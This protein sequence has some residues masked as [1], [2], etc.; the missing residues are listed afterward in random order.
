M[1]LQNL[2]EEYDNLDKR[3]NISKIY[4]AASKLA[5][6]ISQLTH[7]IKNGDT[8]MTGEE[9]DALN[10]PFSQGMLPS[11]NIKPSDIYMALDKELDVGLTTYGYEGEDISFLFD[12][13][14]EHQRMPFLYSDKKGATQKD[15]SMGRIQDLQDIVSSKTGVIST[16]LNDAELAFEE[17]NQ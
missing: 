10:L 6:I 16:E 1:E 2:Y 7:R 13:Y 9:I 3:E 12:F 5:P 14:D 15:H 8:V 17:F 4:T 11:D